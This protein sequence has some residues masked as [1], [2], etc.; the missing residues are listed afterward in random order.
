MEFVG[1]S[2]GQRIEREGK[3]P[4]AEAIRILAQVCQGLHRA[5]KQN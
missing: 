2:L 1:R 3:V 4:E 5:H